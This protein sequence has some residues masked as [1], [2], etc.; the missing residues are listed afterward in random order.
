MA[1]EDVGCMGKS[2]IP[3]KKTA[4]W[5]ARKLRG[6]TDDPVTA[7]YCARCGAY[8]VGNRPE[9]AKAKR[10]PYTR[11]ERHHGHD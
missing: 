10:I 8:H 1:T 7:Y 2:K 9:Y 6:K 11:K 5:L 3:N 4:Q